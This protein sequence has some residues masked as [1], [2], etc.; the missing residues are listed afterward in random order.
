MTGLRPWQHKM[1]SLTSAAS[2]ESLNARPGRPHSIASEPI[3][4]SKSR[5]SPIGCYGIS[6]LMSVKRP[7][8]LCVR[9]VSVLPLNHAPGDFGSPA[10]IDQGRFT[11]PRHPLAGLGAFPLHRHRTMA[12]SVGLNL[13]LRV[14][15][16]ARPALPET[17]R[18]QLSRLPRPLRLARI[19]SPPDACR[20]ENSRRRKDASFGR[21]SSLCLH[22][23]FFDRSRTEALSQ[24][25]CCTKIEN[26]CFLRRQ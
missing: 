10:P 11:A 6:D 22:R 15:A 25:T 20:R 12:F 14:P 5:G 26:A 2:T 17:S 21:R 18:V 23:C 7:S 19:T 16:G 24:N 8:P 13:R 1:L 3:H 4:A 9:M